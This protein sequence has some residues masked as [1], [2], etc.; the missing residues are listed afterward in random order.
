MTSHSL[1][2]TNHDKTLPHNHQPWQVI[3]SQTLTMTSHFIT[4]TNY[5]KS[6]TMTSHSNDIGMKHTIFGT[7]NYVFHLDLRLWY[8]EHW[9]NIY[10][11]SVCQMTSY[12]YCVIS[13]ISDHY[14]VVIC[15]IIMIIRSA[16][17]KCMWLHAVL[18]ICI[19]SVFWWPYFSLGIIPIMVHFMVSI[20]WP[21]VPEH[22][23]V[24]YVMI[25]LFSWLMIG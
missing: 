14:H 2:T 17:N 23:P 3:P 22:N 15:V 21:Y 4:T 11:F 6:I 20:S 25:T 12:F 7:N 16:I 13:C 24:L 8:T 1:T 18:I 5:D 9:Q 10:H 19:N